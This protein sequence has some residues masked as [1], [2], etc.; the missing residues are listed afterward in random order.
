MRNTLLLFLLL[1]AARSLM[2]QDSA[3]TKC[4]NNAARSWWDVQYY[5]LN[6][7]I[8]TG[9]GKLDGYVIINAK[10]IG[11][12]GTALQI[13]LQE[14]LNLTSVTGED[15]NGTTFSFN[16]RKEGDHYFVNGDFE[17]LIKNDSF[18]LK[19]HYN[20][21]PQ[22]AV[23]PPWDGGIVMSRDKNGLPWIAVA[24]QGTG[25]SVWFPCKDFQGD[26]PDNGMTLSMAI[27]ANLQMIGNGRL[28]P[29]NERRNDGKMRWTWSVSNPINNYDISF[30]I[31]DYIHWSDTLQGVKGNLSL[32]YYVLRENEAKAKEHFNVVK[33]M[34]QCFESK[35]GPYP[36]YEDGY[37]LI[38]APYLGM[39][40]QSAVA[41]GNGYVMGYKG[42]DRSKSGVGLLFDFIIVH[43]S[44]HE[45]F[46]NSITAYDVADTW[47][48]EG[49]TTYAETIF[50][51]CLVGKEKAFKYQ[52]GKINVIQN[53]RPVQGR[54]NECDEGSSDHYDKAAFMIH[55]IRMIMNDDNAFFGM[56]KKMNQIYYHKIVSGK[57]IEHFINSYS[58]WNFDKVFDQ[59]LRTVSLPKLEL[60]YKT[61]AIYYKWTNCVDHFN[62]PVLVHQN[63]KDLWLKPTTTFQTLK[64]N[65]SITI[66]KN[67]LIKGQ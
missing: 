13:D 42:M 25:A 7:N 57:T 28:L 9:T 24:C 58:H 65:D 45:W 32:D 60:Q 67:F 36:F 17:R 22:K 37:K 64:S 3:I 29:N 21:I 59:Y 55:M 44:G 34:L 35:M 54:F 53:D 31:G 5:D 20:G 47:I 1:I 18:S 43:E 40:H 12:T 50:A 66:D 39:E 2:A 8:D 38:D 14:P 30:Y 4:T 56:L 11:K 41:Y 16:I 46:G 62:M 6:L 52:Q 49:F 61:G 10:V 48:H 27:P 33:P 23:R 63:G 19:A 51:E 26:E 15:K